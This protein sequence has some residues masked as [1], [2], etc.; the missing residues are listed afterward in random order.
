[1][2]GQQKLTGLECECCGWTAAEG[3]CEDGDDLLCGCAGHISL[4]SE[5]GPCVS[6][7][8]EDCPPHAQCRE[9]P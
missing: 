9:T 5:T 4:D 1:M 3:L 2:S 7:D 6:L 8:G